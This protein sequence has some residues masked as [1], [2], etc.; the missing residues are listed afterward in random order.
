MSETDGKEIPM[1]T[2]A[3]AVSVDPSLL[4]L[5]SNNFVVG[6]KYGLGRII[7][8]QNVESDIR[9][10]VKYSSIGS[11][12]NYNANTFLSAFSKIIIDDLGFIDKINYALSIFNKRLQAEKLKREAEEAEIKLQIDKQQQEINFWTE[13][14]IK[15]LGNDYN[16]KNLQVI[17]ARHKKQVSLSHCAY[18][19]IRRFP[20]IVRDV[21]CWNCTMPLVATGIACNECNWSVCSCGTCGCGYEAYKKARSK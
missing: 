19:G 12:F 17:I 21:H 14:Y 6:K 5:L 2:F 18:K 13:E 20:M 15:I 3:K 7:G 11:A 4:A 10:K 9:I 1:G 16:D 8:K